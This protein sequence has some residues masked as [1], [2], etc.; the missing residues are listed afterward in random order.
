MKIF[1]ICMHNLKILMKKNQRIFHLLKL[2]LRYILYIL[3]VIIMILEIF[4]I[5][6]SIIYI[7]NID[8]KEFLNLDEKVLIIF[9]SE[10]LPIGG[11]FPEIPIFDENTNIGGNTSETYIPKDILPDIAESNREDPEVS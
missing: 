2:R 3:L 10:Q 11:N 5:Y 7:L 4:M 8:F 6:N 9:K 1:K